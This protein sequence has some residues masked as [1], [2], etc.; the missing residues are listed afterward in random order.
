[1]VEQYNE[2]LDEVRHKMTLLNEVIADSWTETPSWPEVATLNYISERLDE[3]FR[4]VKAPKVRDLSEQ[5]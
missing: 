1:M 5:D 4:F 3:I 2:K